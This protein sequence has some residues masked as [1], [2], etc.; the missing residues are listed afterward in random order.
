MN[1]NTKYSYDIKIIE[2]GLNS[3]PPLSIR[4]I[5]RRNGWPEDNTHHWLKRNYVRNIRYKAIN[6]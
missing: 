2:E 3:V 1:R 5:A 4:E 6:Q